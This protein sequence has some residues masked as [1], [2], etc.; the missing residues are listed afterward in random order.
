VLVISKELEAEILRLS[1]VEGWKVGTIATQLGLHHGSVERVLAEQTQPRSRLVRATLLDPYLAFI[2]DTLR[3]FPGLRASRLYDMCVERGYGGAP[4]Q[5]RARIAELRPRPAAEAYLRRTTLAGQEAQVD[6]AHFGRVAIGRASWPLMAFVMVLSFSRRIFLRFF[7]GAKRECFLRGHVQAFESFGGA[8]RMVLYDNL[9]SAVLE[10]VGDAI[11]F[12][13]RLLELAK[14][15]RF[16]PRPVAPC[17]GNEK[18]RVER[19]IRFVRDS[20]FAAR[21]W[22]DLADLNAQA[23]QWCDGRAADRPWPQ[24][25]ARTVRA[26]FEEERGKL[27]A[28]PEAGFVVEELVEV[29][30]GKQPYVRFEGNDY[31][32]PHTRVRRILCLVASETAVRI[33]EGLEVVASHV[34]SYDKGR[35]IE[36]PA[37]IDALIAEKRRGREARATDRLVHAAPTIGRLLEELARRGENLGSAT[38]RF[39]RLLESYGAQR[40]ERAAREAHQRGVPQPRSV[41]LILERERLEEGRPPIVPVELPDDPRVRGV[42]VRPHE[43]SSYEVLTREKEEA[44]DG[45]AQ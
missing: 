28:L 33:L 39:V 1:Q 22:K 14:H 18:G 26:A 16:E 34:R 32:V 36:D 2:E 24:D 45:E 17:R 11:R 44:G 42:S 38:G 6:W 3:R 21:C 23:A 12:H 25:K 35:R 10:R 43:L 29:A 40:L 37:H 9:K 8:A 5:F 15:Y 7:L 30:V 27:I 41:R 20:F 31:S 19:A 13:P 4:S